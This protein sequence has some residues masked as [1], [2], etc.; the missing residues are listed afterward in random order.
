MPTLNEYKTSIAHYLKQNQ[1]RS[2]TTDDLIAAF[3][4][5]GNDRR[6]LG[7]AIIDL[8]RDRVVMQINSRF[9]GRAPS[10]QFDV[11]SER[12]RVIAS[13]AAAQAQSNSH[14]TGDPTSRPV[15]RYESPA[16]S[17]VSGSSSVPS[18]HSGTGGQAQGRR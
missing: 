1:T 10:F 8:Q 15:P 18:Y 6:I 11:Q 4:A 5:T 17:F 14:Y 13:A 16:P 9:P 7:A 12:S 3:G 2:F